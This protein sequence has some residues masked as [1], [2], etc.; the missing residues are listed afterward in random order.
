MPSEDFAELA[1]YEIHPPSVRLLPRAFSVNNDVVVLGEV[2]RDQNEPVVIGMLDTDDNNTRFQIADIL[3]HPIECVRLNEYEIRKVLEETYGAST[4]PD[5][6]VLEER[7]AEEKL[8]NTNAMV[9]RV[10][11][12]AVAEGASDLHIERYDEDVDVRYRLDGILHQVYTDITPRNVQQVV[13]RIKVLS[14]LDIAERRI[15]QDGSFE[16]VVEML[17]GETK[18]IDFRVSIVPGPDGEDVVLRVLDAEAALLPLE[19]LGMLPETRKTFDQLLQNPEG[20]ILVCGPTGSGKTT[21]L[22]AS[23]RQVNDGRRKLVTVEDPIE[24]NLNKINQKQVTEE[25]TFPDMLRALLR[26]DP[27]VMLVGEIRDEITANTGLA[28][29]NTGHLVFGT[30]HTPDAFGSITRLRGLQLD[31]SELSD[32]LLAILAQRLVRRVCPE[33]SQPADPSD[34]MRELFGASVVERLSLRRGTGCEACH[35]TGY[36]GRVGIFEL[37]VCDHTVQNMIAD[38]TDTIDIREYARM[39]G[40]EGLLVD[41]IRKVDAGLTTLEELERIIP[42]R[43]ILSFRERY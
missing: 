4:S 32:A 10:L 14:D 15:P 42:F 38:G 26:H 22:Y 36:K 6:V 34:E 24:Y 29:A 40:H 21:T 3:Q 18:D 19:Q 43:Q 28:A 11:A 8:D 33:C 31:D 23:L 39:Q 37:A 30:V 5:D 9:D 41:A 12:R 2:S 17:D 25:T 20:L 27:D 1:H 13:N 35:H 16:A 7:P